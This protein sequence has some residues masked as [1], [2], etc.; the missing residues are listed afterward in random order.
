VAHVLV[1]SVQRAGTQVRI[2]AQLID[3][4]TDAHLW[5]EHYD[6]P[7]DNV[8]AIQ[9]E[10]AKAITQQL[11]AKLSPVEKAAIEQPRTASL[12][13]SNFYIQAKAVIAT[14]AF[15]AAEDKLVEAAHLLDQAIAKDPNFVVAYCDLAGVHD[16]AYLTGLDHTPARLALAERA[17]QT[18]LRLQPDSGEAHLA[19]A[20]HLYQ[21]YLEYDKALAELAIAART[22]PNDARIFE[23]AGYIIRRQGNQEE[24]ARQLE[25]AV[26]LDPRN[27][28][29]LQQLALSYEAL[30]RYRDALDAFDRALAIV[31]RDVDTKISR[32]LTLLEW[33]A[34]TQPLH[35]TIDELLAAD[36]ADAPHLADSWFY[37]ALC[38][39]DFGSAERALTALGDRVFGP[40]T[41]LFT[42]KFGHGLVARL[43]GDLA[44]AQTAFTEARAQQ[45]KLLAEQGEYGPGLCVLGMIDAALGRKDDALREGR[46]AVEL[47]PMERDAVNSVRVREF[48]AIIYA[49]TGEKDLACQELEAVSKLPATAGYGQLRLHPFW[50]ALRGDPRFEKIVASRAPVD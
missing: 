24:G 43:R 49:W 16:F 41:V 32:G 9:S 6:R 5:A 39:R 18:A 28:A 31:P 12:E 19:H 45:E 50:D 44:G 37:L 29:T 7:L 21:G 11:Q 33:K 47:V 22:L 40:D 20:R 48:L 1:G 2:T 8:F 13:A 25:R 3:A 15:G 14:S 10:I 4:R 26:E 38:E 30:R 35:K 17:A 27:F 46:R 36:P 23:L 42:S 34:E